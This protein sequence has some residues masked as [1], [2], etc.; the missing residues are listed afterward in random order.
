[1]LIDILS[2]LL[3]WILEI[4]ILK[5]RMEILRHNVSIFLVDFFQPSVD[6]INN[7]CCDTIAMHLQM[8]LD[9]LSLLR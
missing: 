8:T 7:S 6:F 1:M 2:D 5:P 4:D 3:K 9:L